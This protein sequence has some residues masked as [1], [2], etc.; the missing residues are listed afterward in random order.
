MSDWV[1][2]LVGILSTVWSAILTAVIPVLVKK[3][4]YK[5][6]DK[7]DEEAKKRE[8]T[9]ALANKYKEEQEKKERA[10][11][12]NT[13]LDKKLVPINEKLDSVESNISELSKQTEAIGD[14]TLSSLRNDILTCYYRCVEKGY[15]NDWDYQN[16]HHLYESYAVL[17]G[18]SY[19]AD[20]MERFDSLPTK[21]EHEKGK[22]S[23]K[24]QLNG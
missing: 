16:I 3:L 7:R 2:W 8:E 22:K 24:K 12:L 21:E 9:Q 20:V 19:V 23:K 10:V 13:M 4:I 11:E 6:F 17:H 5:Y 18:N 15:R 1:V 14:G